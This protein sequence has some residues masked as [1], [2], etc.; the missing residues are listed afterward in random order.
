MQTAM[1]EHATQ[2]PRSRCPSSIH[3]SV[4]PAAPH[5][6]PTAAHVA[7]GCWVLQLGDT[8]TIYLQS[9]SVRGWQCVECSRARAHGIV[10]SAV[11]G[12]PSRVP[13]SY[14]GLRRAPPPS[15]VTVHDIVRAYDANGKCVHNR[16]RTKQCP[17]LALAAC[18]VP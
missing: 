11:C 18:V 5:G 1:R 9:L 7:G 12:L 2:P 17:E 13:T 8:T 6:P 4:Y 15:R 10:Q 14:Y 3:D 16:V